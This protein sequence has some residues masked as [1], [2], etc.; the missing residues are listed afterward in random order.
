MKLLDARRPCRHTT[1]STK[2]FQRKDFKQRLSTKRFQLKTGE[3]GCSNGEQ[4]RDLVGGQPFCLAVGGSF[5]SG[6]AVFS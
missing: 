4:Y 2:D 3:D 5:L 1:L 6:A